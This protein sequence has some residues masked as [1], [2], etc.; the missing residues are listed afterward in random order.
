MDSFRDSMFKRGLGETAS[1]RPVL[2]P[3]ANALFAARATGRRR[4]ASGARRDGQTLRTSFATNH[5]RFQKLLTEV[6]RTTAY[7][8]KP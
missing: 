2:C 1:C 7:A 3:R 5:R 6:A 8:C 4:R